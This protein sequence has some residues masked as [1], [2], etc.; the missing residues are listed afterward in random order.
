MFNTENRAK[1]VKGT[2][3]EFAMYSKPYLD[4]TEPNVRLGLRYMSMHEQSHVHTAF[5]PEHQKER[6]HDQ[7]W[8]FKR[9]IIQSLAVSTVSL[10]SHTRV[11]LHESMTI[12]QAW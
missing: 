4:L 6:A 5:P 1:G 11:S 3:H 8:H 12:F 7:A 9:G 10:P 2:R